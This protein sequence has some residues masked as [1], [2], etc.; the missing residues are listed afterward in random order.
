[1]HKLPHAELGNGFVK[2][3]LVDTITTDQDEMSVDSSQSRC[4]KH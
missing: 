4:V 3:R 1:M 2:L